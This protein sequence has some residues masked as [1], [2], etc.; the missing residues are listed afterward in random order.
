MKNNKELAAVY[1]ALNELGFG[2]QEAELYVTVLSEGPAS[3]TALARKLSIQ[4]P[5]IYKLIDSLI[6]RGLGAYEK[7]GKSKQI[8]TVKPPN[9]I[10]EL[11]DE[12]RG[13]I[14]ELEKSINASLPDLLA[15]YQQGA[16]DTAIKVFKTKEQWMKVFWQSLDEAKGEIEW[17]GSFEDWVEFVTWKEEQRWI[18]ERIRKKVAIKLLFL[19][20]KEGQVFVERA[21][22]KYREFKILKSALD[23]SCSFQT[24]ANKLII[25][26]PKSPLTIMI[27]D[28]YIVESMRGLF[29]SM[30]D[31][32]S[33]PAAE[34]KKQQKNQR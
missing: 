34:W 8:F 9:E 22:E 33:I 21:E 7:K 25:W 30:W 28:E 5:N 16:K 2:S 13:E 19:P 11:L 32:A 3:A 14:G 31:F 12:R 23:F 4:R 26:Q 1:D 24:F 10:N 29:Y 6:E 17:L 18:D 27:E 20:T 15:L